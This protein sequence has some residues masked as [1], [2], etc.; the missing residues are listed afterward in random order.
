MLLIACPYCGPRDQTEFNYGGDAS[1]RRPTGTARNVGAASD[2][3]LD[4]ALDSGGAEDRAWDAYLHLRAN[5]AREHAEWWQH[6]QGCRR[7]IGVRRNTLTHE[8]VSTWSPGSSKT[9]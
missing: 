7:W 6:A 2:P 9:P 5:P 8:I 4:S 3:A 1:V